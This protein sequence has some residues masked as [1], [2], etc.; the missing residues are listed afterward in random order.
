[1]AT[2]PEKIK[3]GYAK[4]VSDE[5][6]TV[7]ANVIKSLASIAGQKAK[8]YT[9]LSGE[10]AD[11]KGRMIET[12]GRFQGQQRAGEGA[13][14]M[15]SLVEMSKLMVNAPVDFA[16]AAYAPDESI[17]RDVRMAANPTGDANAT[18]PETGIPQKAWQTFYTIATPGAGNLW[19]TYKAMESAYGKDTN[20]L[21][22]DGNLASRRQTVM[23][24]IDTEKG[25]AEGFQERYRALMDINGAWE[26]FLARNPQLDPNAEATYDAFS[27]DHGIKDRLPKVQDT[28]FIQQLQ[29]TVADTDT[30]RNDLYREDALAGIKGLDAEAEFLRS[31]LPK[32]GDG[33]PGPTEDT[34]RDLMAAWLKR[35]DVQAWAKA[36][37]LQVGRVEEVTQKQKDDIA[38]GKIP[39][40]TVTKYGM[41]TEGPD[42][43]KAVN[44]AYAQME[45]SPTRNLFRRAGLTR[46]GGPQTAVEVEVGVDPTPY[47]DP[48][49]GKFYKDAK[50]G[51][52]VPFDQVTV[53]DQGNL[54]GVVEVAEPPPVK[55]FRG[56]KRPMYV[57]DAVG[58]VRF[59]DEATGEEA[60]IAPEHIRRV[61]EPNVR[62]DASRPSIG[63]AIGKAVAKGAVKKAGL[64]EDENEMDIGEKPDQRRA[65]F[66]Q[67]P[68]TAK[69]SSVQARREKV[70]E[71]RKN[72]PIVPDASLDEGLQPRKNTDAFVAEYEQRA[73][74]SNQT[75]PVE[76]RTLQGT[77]TRPSAEQHRPSNPGAAAP[78][79]TLL[80][81]PPG[82]ARLPAQNN[83]TG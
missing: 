54:L 44:F 50:T 38:A 57:N 46:A 80:R 4:L 49:N 25:A 45:R 26:N 75:Q 81:D 32:D 70:D 3:L 9:A 37:G 7:T 2:D 53:D 13:Q 34:E 5:E 66:Q 29:K 24:Q 27:A 65:F 47:R 17:L 63:S 14:R 11:L 69:G 18:N 59:V 43:D 76:A 68:G 64:G 48:E 35:P 30:G 36:N 56:V 31:M 10:T 19:G 28:A 58:S 41:Y 52:Y 71:I 6:R 42:D 40:S 16:K 67:Y 8:A 61:N 15:R 74:A 60:Y 62:S 72:L 78:S 23:A 22:Y 39:A 83:R 55:T 79:S 73:Q 21:T 20:A 77:P 12:I 33:Q 1:M 82:P 51:K